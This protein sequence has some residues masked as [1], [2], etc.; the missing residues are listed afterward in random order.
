MVQAELDQVMQKYNSQTISSTTG[1]KKTIGN[2]ESAKSLKSYTNTHYYLTTP[3]IKEHIFSVYQVNL[4]ILYISFL[5][6]KL[7]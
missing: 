5:V 6:N 7:T 2:T 3:F 4:N 1:T